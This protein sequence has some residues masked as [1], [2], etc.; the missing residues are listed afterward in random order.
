MKKTSTSVPT[1]LPGIQAAADNGVEDQ[2]GQGLANL[3][4]D[5]HDRRQIGC[6][7][8]MCS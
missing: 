1:N 8:S 5:T 7:G 2:I 4:L 6:A 3:A